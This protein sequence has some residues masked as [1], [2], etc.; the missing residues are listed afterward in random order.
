MIK[1]FR[2]G[3][4]VKVENGTVSF[5]IADNKCPNCDKVGKYRSGADFDNQMRCFNGCDPAPIW[6]PQN[7]YLKVEEND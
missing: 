1:I 4:T 7:Y 5:W 6:E 2:L 3:T